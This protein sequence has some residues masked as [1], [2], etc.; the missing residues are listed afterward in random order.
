MVYYDFIKSA[1]SFS[2]RWNYILTGG[3]NIAD[4]IGHSKMKKRLKSKL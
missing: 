2:D 1:V 3:T 4:K